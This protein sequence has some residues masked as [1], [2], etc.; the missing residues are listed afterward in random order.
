M[1][2]IVI[3]SIL[4]LAGCVGAGGTAGG[5]LSQDL[6]ATRAEYIIVD[7]TSGAT[8]TSATAPDLTADP[9]RM[10]FRRVPAGVVV[11]GAAPEEVGRQDDEL[12]HSAAVPAYYIAVTECTQGQ[13]EAL[14]ASTP[15]QGSGLP[16]GASRPA[17]GLSHADV[18]SAL[19]QANAR[20]RFG[21]LALPGASEWERACRGGSEAAYSWGSSTS[22]AVVAP[23]AVVAETRSGDGPSVIAGRAPNAL[24]LYDM[25]GNVWEFTADGDLRGGSWLDP[26]TLARAANRQEIEPDTALPIAGVRLCWRPA[27]P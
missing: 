17:Y 16:V 3:P 12:R 4:L 13:W 1:H 6:A 27:A 19:Q 25:H 18:Q 15:W 10:V 14:A 24:G 26:V 22:Q 20:M 5:S 21:R 2:P 9:S 11:Q 8:T 7:I 23:Q